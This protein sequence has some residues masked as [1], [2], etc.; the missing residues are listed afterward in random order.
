MYKPFVLLALASL[1]NCTGGIGSGPR[2]REEVESPK[3]VGEVEKR[4]NKSIERIES[5][6]EAYKKERADREK[7]IKYS[8]EWPKNKKNNYLNKNHY[9]V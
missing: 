2:K 4:L 9:S 7:G 6:K 1:T 3:N 5:P 8:L